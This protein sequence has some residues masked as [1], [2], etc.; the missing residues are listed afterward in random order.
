MKIA[1]VVNIARAVEELKEAGVWTVG[2]AGEATTTYDS[3]DFTMPASPSAWRA[4]SRTV[5]DY[6]AK[7]HSPAGVLERYGRLFREITA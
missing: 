4:A 7:N 1:E 6:F 5:K 2:L 3:I